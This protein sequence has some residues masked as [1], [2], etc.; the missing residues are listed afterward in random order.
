MHIDLIVKLAQTVSVLRGQTGLAGVEPAADRLQLLDVVCI[1]PDPVPRQCQQ[2]SGDVV[3]LS[4]FGIAS[5]FDE[6]AQTI[7]DDVDS[8]NVDG[9]SKLGDVMAA[10]DQR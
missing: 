4:S 7:L 6:K 5:S 2:K 3:G 1:N 10:M 9:A 8:D